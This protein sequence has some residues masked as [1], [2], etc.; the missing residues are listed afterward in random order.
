MSEMN[1][2]MT[3]WSVSHSEGCLLWWSQIWL[4]SYLPL[5]CFTEI[6]ILLMFERNRFI[7]EDAENFPFLISSMTCCTGLLSGR[8]MIGSLDSRR[9]VYSASIAAAQ[10]WLQSRSKT[11]FY[12]GH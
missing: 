7:L 6:G 10:T 9:R 3:Q 4:R 8:I 12:I 1:L 2:C 5:R 11:T